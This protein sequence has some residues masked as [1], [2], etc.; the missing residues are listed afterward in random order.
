[1]NGNTTSGILYGYDRWN[2]PTD[3]YEFDFGH[4]PAAG[5]TCASASGAARHTNSVFAAGANAATGVLSLPTQS[6]VM[7]GSGNIYARSSNTYDT[8]GN[9]LSTAACLSNTTPFTPP[10]TCTSPATSY[11]YD[12]YGNVLTITDGRNNKT[13][14]DY[15]DSYS[16]GGGGNT[17]ALPT[18]ITNALNQST[19]LQYDYNTGKATQVT[20]PNGVET[21][22][23]YNDLLERVTQ[24][25]HGQGTTAENQTNYKYPSV[26]ETDIYQDQKQN[27]DPAA[28]RT[29]SL[30]DGFGRPT[31]SRQYDSSCGSGYIFTKS[32]YD[33]LGR[34]ATTTNPSCPGDGLNYLT[35]ITMMLWGG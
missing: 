3:V 20:D 32:T 28:L 7:D 15:T 34:V 22:Y 9:L 1:M 5:I 23:H 8:H 6:T 19:L 14:I 18:K 13:S 25:V 17:N 33:A 26:T 35:Y 31:E 29:E 10:A 2:N 24:V 16:S 30:Y 12:A 4:A 11:T 27:A 21:A